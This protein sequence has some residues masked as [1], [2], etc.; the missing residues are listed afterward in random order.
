MDLRNGILLGLACGIWGTVS[1]ATDTSYQPYIDQ[2]LEGMPESRR[3]DSESGKVEGQP[4]NS[5][6][7]DKIQSKLRSE[8]PEPPAEAYIEGLRASDPLRDEKQGENY[9]EKL[10]GRIEPKSTGGAIQAY[11]EGKSELEFKRPGN[12][13][14]AMGLRYSLSVNRGIEAAPGAQAA[15]FKSVY[16]GIYD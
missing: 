4:S 9:L 3:L 8:N 12:I 1:W 5:P 7:L 16:G 11:H 14:N 6:Y 2:L 15:S 10:K 13:H